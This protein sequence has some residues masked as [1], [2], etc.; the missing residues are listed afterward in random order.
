MTVLLRETHRLTSP[1]AGPP[2]A[3]ADRPQ[4]RPP[5]THRPL[6][7][8]HRRLGC[9]RQHRSS[10]PATHP[11]GARRPGR[12]AHRRRG[13]SG[14]SAR[15]RRTRQRRPAKRSPN[16]DRAVAGAGGHS[17][18]QPLGPRRWVLTIAANRPA[19]RL[20]SGYGSVVDRSNLAQPE[21]GDLCAPAAFCLRGLDRYR[22]G[23]L[24]WLAVGAARVGRSPDRSAGQR[25][26][27]A[28]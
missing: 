11:A 27:P 9:G 26:A 1:S 17:R 4:P 23:D 12:A 22:F 18:R 2:D 16:D 6:Q 13:H 28:R 21:L 10:Q 5:P 15:Q 14:R 8:Q 25:A 19:R 3:H 7:R 24:A 20:R